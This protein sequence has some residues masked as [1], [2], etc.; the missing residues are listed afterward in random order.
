MKNHLT[1]K[2]ALLSTFLLLSLA[3]SITAQKL[4]M[5]GILKDANGKAVPDGTQSITFNIYDAFSGGNLIWSET[6]NVTVFGGIYS[7]LLGTVNV[8]QPIAN[9]AWNMPYFV[10]INIGGQDI[11]PRTE[12]TYAPYAL[13][14]NKAVYSDKLSSSATSTTY[15]NVTGGKFTLFESGASTMNIGSTGNM[16]VDIPSGQTNTATISLGIGDTDTGLNQNGDGK[17]NIMT[18]A[19]VRIAI[20]PE[21]NIFEKLTVGNSAL[22]GGAMYLGNTNHG[23]QRGFPTYDSNH[24]VGLYT[25]DAN[26][27]LSTN[28]R[29]TGEFVLTDA[30]RVGI[31]TNDPKTLFTVQSSG[32]EYSKVTALANAFEPNFELVTTR[33]VS[34]NNPGDVMAQIGLSYEKDNPQANSM[35][36][37]RR[38]NSGTDGFMSFTSSNTERM[39]I[40]NT[41]KVGIGVTD[42]QC[43]FQVA[44][45]LISNGPGVN[46][47]AYFAGDVQA[48]NVFQQGVATISDARIKNILHVSDSKKDIDILKKIEITDYNLIDDA[49]AGKNSFKKLIAQQVEKVY[50][51][52]VKQFR[53]VLPNVFESAKE[54]KFS[55][56]EL[57][58]TTTKAHDFRKGDR[59]DLITHDKNLDQIV[60][61]EIVNANTFKVKID[62]KPEK[63][64]VYGKWVNDFLAVDY[65]AISMLNVSATQELIRKIE[66]LEKENTTLKNNNGQLKAEIET[67]K[68]SQTALE[69][70]LGAIESHLSK[71]ASN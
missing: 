56:G 23:I 17:M 57:T 9:L 2:K 63:L 64:F 36:Q 44:G 14:V 18:D 43:Q 45:P 49:G 65:E 22:T 21:V 1:I 8:A 67:T 25:S 52:A 68:K 33:G 24:N 29:A 12:L 53:N 32:G 16:R 15:A 19:A 54:F 6:Q 3:F 62:A 50:P 10:G 66:A 37:F 39:R 59:I 51:Q 60:V 40:T 35:I 69:A 38:G 70:R 20:G 58:V 46:V 4:S 28:G 26:L 47:I 30:G 7:A 61:D 27:V 42:P 31:G 55:N 71:T 13:A 48:K 11:T 41:G 5:Q 34:S